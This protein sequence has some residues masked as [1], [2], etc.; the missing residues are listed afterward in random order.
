MLLIGQI[1]D[2]F[3][4]EL[5]EIY[6]S[7]EIDS[8]LRIVVKEILYLN[9]AEFIVNKLKILAEKDYLLIVEIVKKLKKNIPIEYILNKCEFNGLPFYVDKNVLIPRQETEELVEWIK[10]HDFNLALDIGTGS[11]CIPIAISKYKKTSFTAIDI[12]ASAIEIAKNNA[13][14]NEVH[15]DF[16]VA[17]INSYEPNKKFDL[18]VSN[19]PYVTK[20]ESIYMHNNVL[21]NEPKSAIFVENDDP[22]FF[23]KTISFFS[24]NNLKKGGML[25]LEINPNFCEETIEVLKK[26]KFVNIEL[27]KDLNNRNRM[28]KAVLN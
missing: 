6:N 28:L 9:Y 21:L 25:F 23:Y 18:I 2:Y 24:L 12:S 8:L 19:P 14:K 15:I 4:D 22:T 13:I 16:F 20:D 27:K 17:D 3:F 7:R 5:L 26:N 11:G 10:K 1:S